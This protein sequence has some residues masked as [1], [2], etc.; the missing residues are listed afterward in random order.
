MKQTISLDI[1]GM[2]CASCVN[3]IEKVLK[4]DSGVILAS[5]NLAT[6]KAKITFEDSILDTKKIIDIVLKAGYKATEFRK[7][8]PHLHSLPLFAP[9]LTSNSI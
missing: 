9:I 2:T 8:K 7:D 4:K 1:K 6:E 5:V 3:R